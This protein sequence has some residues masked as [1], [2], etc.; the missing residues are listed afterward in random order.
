MNV[1][2]IVL[3]YSI[4]DTF[5]YLLVIEFISFALSFEA[6]VFVKFSSD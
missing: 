5:T 2:L 3:F 6:L 1:I 4:P